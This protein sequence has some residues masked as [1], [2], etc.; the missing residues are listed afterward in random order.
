MRAESTWESQ[1]I[2]PHVSAPRS[3]E[4]PA[5]C[6]SLLLCP[7]SCLSPRPWHLLP[8]QPEMH[9]CRPEAFYCFQWGIIEMRKQ[10]MAGMRARARALVLGFHNTEMPK[11][12]N[13]NQRQYCFLQDLVQCKAKIL[14]EEFIFNSPTIPKLQSF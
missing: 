13:Y 3:G 12:D 7:G 8:E 11:S 2:A 5:G 6:A 4:R 10:R 14:W 9:P 1:V